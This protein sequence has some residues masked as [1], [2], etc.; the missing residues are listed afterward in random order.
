M[1]PFNLLGAILAALD[2]LNAS[3]AALQ[4]EVAAV[5]KAVNDLVAAVAAGNSVGIEAAVAQ[6]NAAA[7]SL[8]TAAASD[9]TP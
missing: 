5:V 4:T 6:I 9:P 7:D 8:K 3:V 2:D 1:W